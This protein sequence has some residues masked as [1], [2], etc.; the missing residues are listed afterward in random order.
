MAV[1]RVAGQNEVYD[2]ML[3]QPTPEEIIAFRPSEASQDRVR[4]LLDANRNNRLTAEESAEL[5]ECM[6][7]EHFMRMLKARAKQG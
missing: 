2:F 1:E 4:Y 6:Q 7:V 5:D 3:S